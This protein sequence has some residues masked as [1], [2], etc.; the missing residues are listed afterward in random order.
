MT[1]TEVSYVKYD[2]C[3][4]DTSILAVKNLPWSFGLFMLAK[5]VSMKDISIVSGDGQLTS[6][7][8]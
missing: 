8:M 1:N 5:G 4:A 3:I 2:R 6:Y 7:P